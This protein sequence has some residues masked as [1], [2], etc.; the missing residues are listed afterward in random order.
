V[1]GAVPAAY[2]FSTA[3][4]AIAAAG[5]INSA[6]AARGADGTASAPQSSSA[7][8]GTL[9]AACII[10][11]PAGTAASTSSAAPLAAA[12]S[13]LPDSGLAPSL[14][15]LPPSSSTARFYEDV[16]ACPSCMHKL[17]HVERQ[18]FPPRLDAR[19]EW[20]A[21]L[22]TQQAARNAYGD[23]PDVHLGV[24]TVAGSAGAGGRIAGRL[25]R[26]RAC[27][28]ACVPGT[29]AGR[30]CALHAWGVTALLSERSVLHVACMRVCGCSA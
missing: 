22:A 19:R 4:D 9:A 12:S 16:Y 14:R 17:V 25:F 7:S 23:S 28:R 20:A 3:S 13:S 10:E 6:V 2:P 27:V 11:A 5:S 21:L 24:R 30:V 29:T 8:A 18:A 15:P 1:E 26:V